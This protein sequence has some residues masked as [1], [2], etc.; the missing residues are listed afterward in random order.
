MTTAYSPIAEEH[1]PAAI[2]S[3]QALISCALQE[4]VDTLA[5]AHWIETAD[6]YRSDHAWMWEI[7]HRQGD[8]LTYETVLEA[9]RS[10]NKLGQIG[11]VGGRTGEEYLD[12]LR[13]LAATT[14]A[15]ETYARQVR[16]KRELRE[17]IRGSE[18]LIG[19]AL[20]HAMADGSDFLSKVE[21]LAGKLRVLDLVGKGPVT[22][23]HARDALVSDI[24]DRY[25]HGTRMI[26]TPLADL[27]KILRGGI[28][29]GLIVVAAAASAGK[30]E[31]ALTL[32]DHWAGVL[33]KHIYWWTG[34]AKPTAL[35][36]RLAQFQFDLGSIYIADPQRAF[37]SEQEFNSFIAGV[38]AMESPIIWDS[39]PATPLYLKSTA[40]SLMQDWGLDVMVIENIDLVNVPGRH[41]GETAKVRAAY[42]TLKQLQMDLGIIIVVLAQETK[43]SSKKSK[44]T[45]QGLSHAGHQDSDIIMLINPDDYQQAVRTNTG[46]IIVAKNRMTGGTGEAEYYR[47]PRSGRLENLA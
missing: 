7:I 29:S 4:P 17:F 44:K 33:G 3:E 38:E 15:A 6:F 25:E 21:D 35:T 40:K 34:E 26:G 18:E 19:L 27:N 30:T 32:I 45:M 5:K 31:T 11:E 9:L 2:E 36:G 8:K 43:E 13:D 39:T 37:V 10:E 16:T 1:L 20:R 46:R 14:T 12:W 23:A 28:E 47:R 42:R 24:K 22:F 41:D